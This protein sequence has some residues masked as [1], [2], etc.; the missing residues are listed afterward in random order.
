MRPHILLAEDNEA[1]AKV[2]AF[3]LEV[4]GFQV[5]VASSGTEAWEY[6]QRNRVDLLITDYDLPK[7]KGADLCRCFREEERYEETPIVL[8]TAFTRDLD[9]TQLRDEV[10]LSATYSKPFEMAEL[11]TTISTL[12]AS[13]SPADKGRPPSAKETTGDHKPALTMAQRRTMLRLGEPKL[14]GIV[15]QEDNEIVEQLIELQLVY[16][17]DSAPGGLSVDFTEAGEAT[18]SAFAHKS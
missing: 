5:S 17:R 1:L 13:P 9:I 3:N 7:M 6:A 2:M 12:L 18:F 16:K 4:A 10:G 15:E 11:L 14:I 8:V